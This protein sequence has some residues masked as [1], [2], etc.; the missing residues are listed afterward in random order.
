MSKK[1]SLLVIPVCVLVM[2]FT[3]TEVYAYPFEDYSV[4]KKQNNQLIYVYDDSI[5]KL[6][7]RG[8]ATDGTNL[9][10]ECNTK[11][12][13]LLNMDSNCAISRDGHIECGQDNPRSSTALFDC[14]I[15]EAG[16]VL[17]V[18]VIDSPKPCLLEFDIPP[19]P[20]NCRDL[21]K[22]FSIYNLKTP[23]LREGFSSLGEFE[24]FSFLYCDFIP[25]YAKL[26]YHGNADDWHL[27]LADHKL[28]HFYD[29]IPNTISIID[30]GVVPND[31]EP[32][33]YWGHGRFFSDEY[34]YRF[35]FEVW[36]SGYIIMEKIYE[37]EYQEIPENCNGAIVTLIKDECYFSTKNT[38]N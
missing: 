24:D 10:K 38:L 30:N 31:V 22:M 35:D 29:G 4:M 3:S 21:F 1:L 33:S 5:K 6:T 13:D 17:C 12:I 11:I 37:Y 20:Q 19:D 26:D 2:G 32:P 28:F 9:T 36:N 14:T 16:D 8:F 25:T 34:E 7:E 15:L 18:H 23:A 27:K